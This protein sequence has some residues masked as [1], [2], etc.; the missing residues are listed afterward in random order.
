VISV[1]NGIVDRG[2]G[3]SKTDIHVNP[4]L[5]SVTGRIGIAIYAANKSKRGTTD[6]V[7]KDV[8]VYV[9]EVKEQGGN[10]IIDSSSEFFNNANVY[11]NNILDRLEA[12]VAAKDL[13]SEID[14]HRGKNI[15]EVP[16]A[17][18]SEKF[19]KTLFVNFVSILMEVDNMKQLANAQNNIDGIN[20]KAS[21]DGN[22]DSAVLNEHLNQIKAG[23]LD[24]HEAEKSLGV[25]EQTKPKK[26][27]IFGMFNR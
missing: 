12:S 7:L 9:G 2:I 6:M 18:I 25:G 27:G 22:Y 3:K 8:T 5:G 16:L 10:Y 11:L 4:K 1:H 15:K 21:T 26:G 17:K 19:T 23:E 13:S 24:A 14:F 20:F